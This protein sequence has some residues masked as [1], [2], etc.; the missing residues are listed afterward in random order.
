MKRA[1]ILIVEDDTATAELI[2]LLLDSR[3]H[4]V[5]GIVSSGD[6]AI[7]IAIKTPPDLVLMDIRIKGKIDGIM[8]FEQIRKVVNVPVVFVSA[9][10]DTEIIYRAMQCSP[11]GYIVKPFKNEDL[12]RKVESV[13]ECQRMYSEK[14]G[15]KDHGDRMKADS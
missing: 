5:F 9:C 14:C 8:A 2:K 1:N 4:K 13:L 12:L 3:G 7:D 11:S 10:T 15:M 6:R